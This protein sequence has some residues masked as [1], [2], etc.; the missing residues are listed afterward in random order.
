MKVKITLDRFGSRYSR[1][2]AV[3]KILRDLG[4]KV[5]ISGDVITVENWDEQK[6]TEILSREGVNYERSS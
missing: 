3:M 5:T 6:V 4:S 2:Q 1:E